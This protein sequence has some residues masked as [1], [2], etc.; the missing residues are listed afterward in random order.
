MFVVYRGIGFF[1][2]IKLSCCGT[3]ILDERLAFCSGMRTFEPALELAHLET[4]WLFAGVLLG[5]ALVSD[6]SSLVSDASSL[7]SDP[8]LPLL[9]KLSDIF[10]T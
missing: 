1:C 2:A 7:V 9:V 3:P 10:K 4:D 5:K 8:S 6:A